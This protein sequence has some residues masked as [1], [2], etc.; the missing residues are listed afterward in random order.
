MSKKDLH[1]SL[2]DNP[3]GARG[4]SISDS[5]VQ[6][7]NQRKERIRAQQVAAESATIAS[8][9]GGA[10][11]G[12]WLVVL[13]LILNLSALGW[14][15]MEIENLKI[16]IF[17]E[18]SFG[19]RAPRQNITQELA[20]TFALQQFK[21]D[22]LEKRLVSLNNAQKELIKQNSAKIGAIETAVNNIR[23]NTS[24]SDN[25]KIPIQTSPSPSPSPSPKTVTGSSIGTWQINLGLFEEP[26]RLETLNNKVQALGYQ[27]V[28]NPSTFNNVP[29]QK[30]QATGFSSKEEAQQVVAVLRQ[31]LELSGIW[32]SRVKQ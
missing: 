12:W 7:R 31:Q 8:T 20:D 13:L 26:S 16:S 29:V 6:T 1:F 27:T 10:T 9:N 30:L 15:F 23:S 18:T 14:I 28:V 32:V 2:P 21:I 11:P 25:R 17:S 19:K 24:G 4:E 3:E 22:D 5:K